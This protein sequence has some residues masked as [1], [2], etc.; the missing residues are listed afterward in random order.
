M[1]PENS[2]GSSVFE[3]ASVKGMALCWLEYFQLADYGNYEN[4]GNYQY[5]DKFCNQ[6][7]KTSF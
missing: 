1:S 6:E 4:N 7:M 3:M 2:F 5:T